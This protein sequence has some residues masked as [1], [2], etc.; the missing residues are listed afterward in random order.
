MPNYWRIK[1]IKDSGTRKRIATNLATLRR[2][3][4]AVMPIRTTDNTLLLGTWNIRNFDNNRFM[5]GPRIDESFYYLA[6]MIHAFDVV[7][8]QEINRSL[9]P[10]D[11]LMS[12]LGPG[13]DY[14]VTD[15][16]E[17]R[18]GNDERLGFIYNRRKVSF[19]GIAGEV[20]LP[21]NQEIR[22]LSKTRQFART[23]YCCAFQAGWFRFMFATVHVYYGKDG[24]NTPQFERRVKEIDTVS[25][26][27]ARRA[28]KDTYNYVLV[29][30]F[31]IVDFDNATFNALEKHGF[32]VFKNR[33][34][35]NRDQTKFYD[36]ISFKPRDGELRLGDSPNPHGV[37]D[38]FDS[39]FTNGQFRD[40]DPHVLETLAR[41]KAKLEAKL[42]KATTQKS[43]DKLK[44]QIADVVEL[45]TSEAKRRNYYK[46]TW[47]T[48]QIS[49]HLP[50][51]VELKI[52]FTDDY[53]DALRD[54]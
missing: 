48:F 30:D 31:N 38:I 21:D 5:N 17:G 9:K 20:V 14:I 28:A 6:E 33:E 44:D 15:T 25:K 24:E 11:K 19:K 29:G 54:G 42:A 12:V 22:D 37:F 4:R 32:T 43:I 41:K 45:R 16:T 36:Q 10:L 1:G 23:P 2:D 39:V 18:S 7:A 53:L 27:L 46:K 51:W 49:D 40:Y 50:L 26:F 34:G 8:I 35:S 13:Y 47:R 52:D 3:I